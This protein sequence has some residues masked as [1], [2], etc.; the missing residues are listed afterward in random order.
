MSESN[1]NS[2][3]SKEIIKEIISWIFWLGGALLIALVL[4]KTIIVNAEVVSGSMET[5]IM[6]DDRVLGLR[7]AYLFGEPKRL[8]VVVFENPIVDGGDPYVKRIIGMPGETI[9]IVDG[10]IYIDGSDTPLDES[11]YLSEKMRGSVAPVTVPEGCYYMLGDNRN[12]STDSRSWG[13]MKRE[14]I[15]G[16]IYLDF[17]PKIKLIK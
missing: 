7:V 8:D 16:K 14:D 15:L 12:S 9:E 10:K 13:F 4:N 11:S 3:K 17:Y 5:T 2:A 6:T 1:V